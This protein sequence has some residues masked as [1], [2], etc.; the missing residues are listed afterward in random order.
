M[1]LNDLFDSIPPGGIATIA[2]AGYRDGIPAKEAD[3]GTPQG[4][5]R[6]PNGDLA[7]A[8]MWGHRIWRI[9]RE[10]TLH[11]IAGDGVPG[12][13]GD[14]GPASKARVFKPHD[15]T[16]DRHGNMYFSDNGNRTYRRIDYSTGVITR[17]AGSGRYGRGGDG[18]P[19]LEAEFDTI[20]GVAVDDEGNIFVTG[21]WMSNV[22]RVDAR[23]GVIEVYAGLSA[24]HY[25]AERGNSRPFA[26]SKMWAAGY[27]G[28]GGPKEN[29]TFREPEHLALDSKGNLYVCDNA[30]NRIR[31]IDR[32]TG[33]VSTVIGTG[34]PSSAG[35]GGPAV[36]ASINIPDAIAIDVHDNVYIGEKGGFRVR[37]ID[38][39]TG[40]VSTLV[41][42]GVPGMGEE[43]VPGVESTCNCVEAGLWADPDG[44]VFW[45]DSG[46]R[47]R[48]YDP[49]TGRVST[50]LGGTSVHDGGPEALA[51]ICGP[52]GIDVGPDGSIYFADTWGQRVRAIGP[53]GIIRTIAGNGAR[54][55][56]GDGG[57]A[58]QAY[59]GN[60]YDVS[61]D[62]HGRI[63]IADSRHGHVRRIETDGTIRNVA[64]AAFQWD[65]GDGGPAICAN[66]M[67]PQ[68]VAYAPNGDMYIADGPAG[69]I[70]KVDAA[71]GVI[72]T[73]AGTGIPGYKGDGGPAGKARIGSARA[74][75]FDSS[76]NLYF[77]DEQFHVVRKVDPSGVITT[78]LGTGVKGFSPDGTP[79]S[80]A[81]L[82]TPSGLEVTPS[83]RIYVSDTCN[84]AVRTV[85]DGVLKT[86]AG[87]PARPGDQ[88]SGGP[89]TAAGLNWPYG[90]RIYGD[91]ILLISD[92]WNGRI[93]AVKLGRAAE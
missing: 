24:R 40:I 54:A 78:V 51:F 58:T 2:G 35:D 17:V 60:P 4:V 71:T 87:D 36:E 72:T 22:R 68:A 9:D 38:A 65:K 90:L 21:P 61:V 62:S 45:G 89:A 70:R 57:E 6:L 86:V 47:L 13:S 73:F 83:G 50:I 88:G 46:G 16:I 15:L 80:R 93:K 59:L 75:R 84:N 74:I 43:D 14:G 1:K 44:T 25:P 34:E 30:N 76:G 3:A 91:S 63:A 92:H 85:E 28:D 27:S 19:A 39:K 37:K 79:A 82:D 67:Y 64:G 8:D 53:D 5:A 56:G 18:G 49:E 41:G 32:K 81:K 77:V 20:S 69:R 29:A 26:G 10:G 48:K 52:G 33:I 7:V 42:T 55:Y 31:K 23:T 12:R 11:T 66:L